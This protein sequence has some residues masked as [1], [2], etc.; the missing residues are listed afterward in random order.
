MSAGLA[1]VTTPGT[2]TTAG[3]ATTDLPT[4][5]LLS[6]RSDNTRAAYSRDLRHF[7]EWCARLGIDPLTVQRPAVDA[8]REQLTHNGARPTTVARAL[9]ALSSF[10]RYA[11]SVGA[12]P[13]NPVAS[14]TRP[15]TGEAYV[16]LTPALTDKE[17]R[18]LLAACQ[19]PRERL[20]VALLAVQ[21]LRVTEALSINLEDITP[22]RGHQTVRIVGKGGTDT[23]V[24]LA[25]LVLAALEDTRA[26]EHRNT[27]PALLDTQG[28][29]MSRHSAAWI[30]D[31]LAR[32]AGI[33]QKV[34]PHQLRATAIT[35]ALDNNAGLRDVQDFA[36]HS[37]PVTTRRYDRN[38]GALDRMAA[39]SGV[40]SAALVD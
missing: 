16:A 18:Q 28:N 20:L 7:A 17:A 9:A 10:Y 26:T 35:V 25:P 34:T 39:L 2:V 31:K 4:A 19:T 21:A 32:R 37:S 29:R 38:R 3:T 8:Y 40:L 12:V 22:E 30:L 27:G 14:V 13:A 1:T 23:R 5:W 24:P 36:R 11:E 6:L 15:R 33:T